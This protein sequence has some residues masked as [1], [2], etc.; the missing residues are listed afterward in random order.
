[1][2][3]RIPELAKFQGTLGA[4]ADKLY[5]AIAAMSGVD[6]DLQRLAVYASMRSDEDT[7]TSRAW[8]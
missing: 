4:S 7:A 6:K 3:K 5:T 2:A 8:R 1:V